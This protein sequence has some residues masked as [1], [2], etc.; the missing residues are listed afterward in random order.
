[1]NKTLEK[2]I[3]ENSINMVYFLPDWVN[4]AHFNSSGLFF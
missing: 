3:G 1:M 2:D 4:K